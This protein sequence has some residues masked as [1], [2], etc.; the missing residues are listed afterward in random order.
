VQVG[1]SNY[2][3]HFCFHAHPSAEGRAGGA[4]TYARASAMD[5]DSPRL[6]TFRT[7]HLASIIIS[8]RTSTIK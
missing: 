8:G 4:S 6:K 7:Y 3:L 1:E 2:Q 5:V